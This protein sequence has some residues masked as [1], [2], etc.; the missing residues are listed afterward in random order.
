M[1]RSSRRIR[2]KIVDFGLAKTT[3]NNLTASGTLVAT[4]TYMSPE[5]VRGEKVH[6]RTD[7]WSLGVVHYETLKGEPPFR[8][9]SGTVEQ[10]DS[11]MSDPMVFNMESIY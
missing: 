6:A 9:E 4:P 2:S 7:V 5:Q 11:T 10:I 3:D 8:S 1:I